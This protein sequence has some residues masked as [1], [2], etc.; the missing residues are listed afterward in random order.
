MYWAKTLEKRKNLE[1]W[2]RNQLFFTVSVKENVEIGVIVIDWLFQHKH[3]NKT[4]EVV[5]IESEI[6]FGI[7]A[8]REQ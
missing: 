4:H 1:N 5:W 3:V 8:M 7:T 2:D 6:Y